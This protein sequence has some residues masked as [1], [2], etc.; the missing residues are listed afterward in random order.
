MAAVHFGIS[1]QATTDLENANLAFAAI[2]TVEFVIKVFGLQRKYFQSSWNN[3][4]FVV[5]LITDLGLALQYGAN[6]NFGPVAATVRAVRICR[7]LRLI[8]KLQT[9]KSLFQAMVNA[10]PSLGNVAS[11]L[12]L[13]YYIFASLG[14]QVRL[15]RSASAMCC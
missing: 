14:M 12:F 6:L 11:L 4:D 9:L 5:V 13:L 8:N 3:F 1:D 10:L 7:I 15:L 2:F